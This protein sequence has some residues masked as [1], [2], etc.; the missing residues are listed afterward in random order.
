ML[1]IGGNRLN[2][3]DPLRGVIFP[4]QPAVQGSHHHRAALFVWNHGD[5]H[6]RVIGVRHDL[7][8]RAPSGQGVLTPGIPIAWN[9]HQ[10]AIPQPGKHLAS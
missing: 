1:P 7:L 3:L 5:G 2:G 9:N 6:L 8:R 4:E 10:A